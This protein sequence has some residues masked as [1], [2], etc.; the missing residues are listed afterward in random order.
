M[1]IRNENHVVG[2]L[3]SR[4]FKRFKFHQKRI[5]IK[6]VTSQLSRGCQ[7]YINSPDLA[8]KE[9]GVP[10]SLMFR[11]FSRFFM[12]FVVVFEIS[13]Y[14]VIANLRVATKTNV[15]LQITKTKCNATTMNCCHIPIT[16]AP[17]QHPE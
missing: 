1:S 10:P 11:I 15:V 2:K 14:I 13:N 16:A 4:A 8:S 12:F 5:Y 3:R 7:Q 17:L 6:K 9:L